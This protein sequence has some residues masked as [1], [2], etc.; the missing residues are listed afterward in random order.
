MIQNLLN[1]AR[2][3]WCRLHSG[4]TAQARLMAD[5][6]LPRHEFSG[7]SGGSLILRRWNLE[8]PAALAPL[9][10]RNYKT[11]SRLQGRFGSSVSLALAGDSLRVSFDGITIDAVSDGDIAVLEEV[12]VDELYR[13]AISGD[14]PVVVWDVGMNV[15][16][17]SLYLARHA[18]VKS[19]FACELFRPTYERALRNFALNPDLNSKITAWCEGVSDENAELDLPYAEAIQGIVGLDGPMHD[20]PEVPLRT[21]HVHVVR[22]TEMLTRILSASPNARVV[23]KMDCEGAEGRVLL[24]LEKSGFI[25]RID[26]MLMEWHGTTLLHEV[27][28]LLTR[29]GFTLTATRFKVGDVG[30]LSAFRTSARGDAAG[31]GPM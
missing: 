18:Q 28:A 6:R 16:A 12:F 23:M 19:V 27:E 25:H 8:V 14:A 31:E 7:G 2:T 30:S 15:G 20:H 1:E 17:A 21:E 4:N 11:L 26:L 22:A 24:D 10:L 3:Q 9:A 5:F 29:N 13:F